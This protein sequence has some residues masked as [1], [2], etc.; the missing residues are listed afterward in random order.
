[1]QSQ[2]LSRK[3]KRKVRWRST[4][5]KR[6]GRPKTRQPKAGEAIHLSIRIDGA[7]ALALDEEGERM[8]AERPGPAFT[9]T[10]VVR[11]ALAE[12][13]ASRRKNRK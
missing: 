3:P 10:D 11:V 2:E 6:L 13:L 9:R 7:M 4:S 1:M 8:G 12:W 5:E